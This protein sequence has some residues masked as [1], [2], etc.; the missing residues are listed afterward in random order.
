LQRANSELKAL[1]AGRRQSGRSGLAVV[2]AR[3]AP[4]KSVL[5]GEE[6]VD[7]V[8]ERLARGEIVPLYLGSAGHLIL[9]AD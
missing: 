1:E 8:Y 9:V 7:D 4:E 3:R 5:A 2:R 6:D